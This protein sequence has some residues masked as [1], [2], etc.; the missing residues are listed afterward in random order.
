MDS[1]PVPPLHPTIRPSPLNGEAAPGHLEE[2]RE[3][4]RLEHRRRVETK[5]RISWIPPELLTV[6]SAVPRSSSAVTRDISLTGVSFLAEHP[7]DIGSVCE[8]ELNGLDGTVVKHRA[9]V[10]RCITMGEGFEV[11]VALRGRMNP[12]V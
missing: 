1:R 4:R 11:A 6:A 9:E 5:A 3:E 2:R 8:I 12:G 7:I 10:V